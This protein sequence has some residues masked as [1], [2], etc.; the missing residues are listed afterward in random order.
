MIAAE[1]QRLQ[2]VPL[3]GIRR[4]FE[5]AR[6]LERSGIDVIHLELGR[7]DFD[8]PGH[9]KD[10]AKLAL[11][12]GDVHYTS[13]YG[14]QELC[15]AI[16]SKFA[17]ENGLTYDSAGEIIVTVGAGE[18]I[19]LIMAAYLNPGEEVLVPD[20][21]WLNYATVPAMMGARAVPVPLDEDTGYSLTVEALE[22]RVTSRTR[23]IILNS[24]HNPTGAGFPR[25]TLEAL[26]AVVDRHRL[27]VVSDEIYEHITYDGH[28]H[29]SFA[30]LPG[31]RARTFVVNGV[32]KAYSMTGW[33]VGYVA[34]P[35]ELIP[36]ILKVH[37][38]LTTCATS[39]AQAGAA[40]AL[41]GPQQCVAVMVAE[42]RR[43][44]DELYSRI[45]AIPNVTCVRP[46]GAFYVFPDLRSFGLTSEEMAD[47]LLQEGHI[48][49]VPGSAFGDAGEGHVRISYCAAH[50]R[51]VEGA[52]RMAQALARLSSQGSVARA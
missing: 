42:F 19:F 47:Y 37:Q 43:R 34:A 51:I 14:T 12:R 52:L 27:W 2:A 4:I 18:A 22:R 39:F 3:S 23:G 11:D 35:R 49:V 6:Q 20:P 48:A 38:Y 16:A 50:E 10:A 41:A 24:P 17:R 26:A 13:N 32:S 36:P 44:R 45:T 31:M 5:A 21:G 28:H 30:S 40:A 15:Q 33:R 25:E 8:T 7:P 9:I 29:T 1:A 46:R